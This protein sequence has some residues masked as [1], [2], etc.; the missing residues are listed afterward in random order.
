MLTNPTA[1]S[2]FMEFMDRRRRSLLVQFWLTVE[3]FKNPLESVDTS[4]SDDDEEAV[5]DPTRSSTLKEDI[6]MMKELYFSNPRRDPALKCI[7]PKYVDAICS[8]GLDNDASGS[9]AERKVRRS[10]MLAQR[11]VEQDMEQDFEE[12]QRSDLWF[13]IVADIEASGT[14]HGLTSTQQPDPPHHVSRD[15]SES[16]LASSGLFKSGFTLPSIPSIRVDHIM[17]WP[18]TST[19]TYVDDV[20]HTDRTIPSQTAPSYIPPVKSSASKLE[21][22]MSPAPDTDD[23]ASPTSSRAPLFN[24]PEDPSIQ[25]LASQSRT[26]EA[27]QAALTDIIALDEQHGNS[28]EPNLADT[29]HSHR[30]FAAARRCR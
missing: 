9:I 1:L 18:D 5:L 23:S 17:S 14:K 15:P 6:A 4:L 2:Y 20:P 29:Y 24:D 22:L 7:S 19:K 27:I 3:S 21:L 12:L 8:F 11:Q 25:D 30:V 28:S 26:V 10:V 16:S 13:R